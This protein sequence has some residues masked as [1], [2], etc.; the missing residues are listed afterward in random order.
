MTG[1]FPCSKEKLPKREELEKKKGENRASRA[2]YRKKDAK[3]L[4]RPPVL[5]PHQTRQVVQANVIRE[6]ESNTAT[7][8]TQKKNSLEEE[9]I[10]NR[11]SGNP[12]TG[13]RR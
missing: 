6:K 11:T 4:S 2:G 10:K 1:R 3:F 7:G 9:R 13:N 8:T 12:E 5:E